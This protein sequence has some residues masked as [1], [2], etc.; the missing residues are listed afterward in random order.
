[1]WI[2]DEE[3]RETF[4]TSLLRQDELGAVIRAQIYL[5]HE[6]INFAR[7]RLTD[8]NALRESE[9]SYARLVRR[10]DDLGLLPRLAGPLKAFGRIRNSFAHRL[11]TAL[12]ETTVKQFCGAFSAEMINEAEQAIE[13]IHFLGVEGKTKNSLTPRGLF[14]MY[15]Y[16]LWVS[17]TKET[18]QSPP[19]L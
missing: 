1:M 16:Y 3:E 5:E 8:P 7:S 6:L 2:D 14:I 19:N 4:M 10:A 17:L 15:A 13:R 11:D 9:F 12:T 18:R